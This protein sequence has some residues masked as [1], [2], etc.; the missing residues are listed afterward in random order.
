[1]EQDK[2]LKV[3]KTIEELWTFCRKKQHVLHLFMKVRNWQ[4]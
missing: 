2:L 1:M 4:K 3:D